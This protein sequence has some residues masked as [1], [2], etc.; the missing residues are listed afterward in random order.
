VFRHARRLKLYTDENPAHDVDLGEKPI[1][2]KRPTYTWDQAARVL[3]YLKSPVKEMALLSIATSMNV[4]EMCGIREKRC[5]FTDTVL[6]VD[7]EV[8]APYSIAV[9]ENYYRNTYGSLKK[10]SR[11]RNVPITA[12]LAGLL[13]RLLHGNP[14]GPLFASRNGT[15]LDAHNIAAD[16][17]KPIEKQLGFPVTWHAFRRAHS[18]FAGQLEGIPI[19]DRAATMGHADARMSMYYSVQD[20]ERRRRLPSEILARIQ[21]HAKGQETIQ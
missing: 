1:P 4:A 9:R 3:A 11:C 18:S 6:V 10:G 17:F 15:P 5:N 19:E 2:Q 7:G 16:K 20:L 13:A 21:Q 8:M 12:E 14:E